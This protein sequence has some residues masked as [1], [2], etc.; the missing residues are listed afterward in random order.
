M[1]ATIS[2]LRSASVC[3]VVEGAVHGERTLLAREKRVARGKVQ[4]NRVPL[5]PFHSDSDFSR[6][7]MLA[8][9]IVLEVCG[10]QFTWLR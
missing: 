10:A 4:N 1:T 3:P 9:V 7:F 8:A 6:T 5:S 2:R